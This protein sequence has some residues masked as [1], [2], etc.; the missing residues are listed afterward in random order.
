MPPELPKQTA[1][2]PRKKKALPDTDVLPQFD[3][4]LENAHLLEDIL[5]ETKEKGAD[6]LESLRSEISVTEVEV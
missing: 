5:N 3:P 6:L 4:K 1:A 2:K